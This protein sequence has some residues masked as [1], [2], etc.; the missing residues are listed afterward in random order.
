MIFLVCLKMHFWL[1]C[2]ISEHRQVWGTLLQKLKSAIQ[3]WINKFKERVRMVAH[4]GIWPW[5]FSVLLN[6]VSH[7]SVWS[8]SDDLG[9]C[10]HQLCLFIHFLLLLCSTPL[11]EPLQFMCLFPHRRVQCS[12][13]SLVWLLLTPVIEKLTTIFRFMIFSSLLWAACFTCAMHSCHW[14]IQDNSKNLLGLQIV[15]CGCWILVLHLIFHSSVFEN[16]HFK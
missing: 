8:W 9:F 6:G 1:Q 12:E 16:W 3:S 10:N 4:S 11:Y 15:F 14:R 2:R 5:D 7:P 13:T